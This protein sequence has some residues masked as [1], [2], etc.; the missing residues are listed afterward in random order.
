VQRPLYDE[1]V[2]ALVTRAESLP[3]G[4][5]LDE[6]TLLGPLVSERQVERVRSF[7]DGVAD[8]GGT[9]VTG[10]SIDGNYVT[11][12]IVTDVAPD[13]RVASEEVFGPV[14]CV[15]A[16]DGE[17]EAI[18]L[19]NG[20]RYGLGASVWTSDVARV[21]RVARR[22]EAGDVWVNTHY[23]RQSETPFGGWKQSGIGRELGMAGMS[24][25]LAYKRVAFDTAPDFHLKTWFE[26]SA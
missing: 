15:F 6:S 23:I 7:L 3:M 13:S 20:V 12:T 22:L 26:G 9:V 17:D 11:P 21:L 5:P 25:Y 10:G 8:E 1:F 18:E 24:E 14:V 16:T 4:D 2:A 19:A